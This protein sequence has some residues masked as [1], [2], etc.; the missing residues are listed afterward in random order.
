M[1]KEAREIGKIR[2]KYPKAKGR[3]AVWGFGLP[4]IFALGALSVTQAC[5]HKIQALETKVAE[6]AQGDGQMLL[7]NVFRPITWSDS[8]TEDTRKQIHAFNKGWTA[9]CD[10][11]EQDAQH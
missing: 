3:W 8:D 9:V 2:G 1:K 7:C 11:R 10:Q 6:M 5:V 4:A